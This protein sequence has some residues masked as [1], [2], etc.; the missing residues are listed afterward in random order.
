[1]KI[2]IAL[3]LFF[4]VNFSFA[5]SPELIKLADYMTGS[6]SSEAQ[7]KADTANY[8]DIRLQIIRIWNNRS[9]GYWF[10]VE[11]AVAESLDKPYRQRVYHLTE[12]AKGIF[13]SEVFTMNQPLRFANQSE[14]LEK[15]LSPDSLIEREGCAVILTQ[16][17]KKKFSGSTE[18]KKCPSDRTGA[19]YATSEVTILQTELHSWDRGY[20]KKDEQVWGATLGGYIFI[21]KK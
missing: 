14:L 2:L 20:N 4:I 6:Y 18:G 12:P 9:D 3:T 7:H 21:K 13:S 5:Q 11:Q 17:N 8:F 15:T 10:Y 19:S 16:I 1:M